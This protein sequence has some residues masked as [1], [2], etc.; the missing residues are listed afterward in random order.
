M[1]LTR[2]DPNKVQLKQTRTEHW[3]L[4]STITYELSG[5]LVEMSYQGVPLNDVWSEYDYIGLFFASYIHKPDEKGIHFFG[6]ARSDSEKSGGK[7]IYHLPPGHGEAS[8]HRPA[9]SKWDPPFDPGFPLTLVS[10]FSEY[11]YIYPFYYGRSGEQVL[12]MMFRSFDEESELRFAQ[13]PNG[14]GPEHPAWDFIYFKKDYEV[15]VSFGFKV[16][17]IVKKFEGKQDVIR[18]YE[19]WS[20]NHVE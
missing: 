4:Q 1:V 6:R 15:N 3:P 14:G 10:G 13:S 8:N 11:E 18:Q 9:E 12:I 16:G 7:W 17:M 19:K 2:L 5:N 20:E